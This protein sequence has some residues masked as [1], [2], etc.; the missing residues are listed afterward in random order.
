MIQTD[1]FDLNDP[2]VQEGIKK[3][4]KGLARAA[5]VLQGSEVIQMPR[6]FNLM[7][8][9]ELEEA[10]EYAIVEIVSQLME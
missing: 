5:L 1:G 6:K 2:Q 9:S 4:A 10:I 7:N 8:L 3:L